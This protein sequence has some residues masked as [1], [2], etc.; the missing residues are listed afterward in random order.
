MFLQEFN[1]MKNK[2]S[3]LLPLAISVL[4][5]CSSQPKSSEEKLT[6]EFVVLSE[7]EQK[8]YIVGDDFN[9]EGLKVGFRCIENGSVKEAQVSFENDTDLQ[10]GQESVTISARLDGDDEQTY[11]IDYPIIVKEEFHIA[12]VGDSLTAGHSWANESYPTMLSGL[13]SEHY[14]VENCGVNGISI[15]GYGGSWDD[16]DMRYIKQDVYTKSVNFA[17]DIFAI[18]LG[19]NDATGWAKAEPTFVDEYHILLDSYTEQFPNAKFI[20]M[21]SPPT[22][23]G[24]QFGIPNDIIK[25]QVNPVQRDLAEEYGFEVLDLREEFEAEPDYE[26]K[27]LRPNNDGVHFTKDAATYVAQRVWDIAKDLRF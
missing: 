3:F 27:Y 13:V 21:V 24:N 19:T 23:D 15:T 10:L 16:P 9:T 7:A 14:K 26:S 8:T 11:T 12:C 6:Y 25:E 1:N 20:M 5:G 22:K 2:V 18:M 17:P 4:V